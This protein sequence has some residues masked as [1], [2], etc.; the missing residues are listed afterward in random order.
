[1]RRTLPQSMPLIELQFFPGG[2]WHGAC[3]GFHRRVIESCQDGRSNPGRR[4]GDRRMAHQGPNNKEGIA[5]RIEPFVRNVTLALAGAAALVAALPAHAED[6][7][8]CRGG[9]SIMLMTPAECRTFLKQLKDARA[10]GDRR[11]ERDLRE[12]HTELLIQRAETCPC[13]Q[14]QPPRLLGEQT[15]SRQ[16]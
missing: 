9:Y 14:G 2:R 7:E 8:T 12:W 13:L 16:P 3:F 5:M 4:S 1:M 15:A 10:R 6:I 11:A